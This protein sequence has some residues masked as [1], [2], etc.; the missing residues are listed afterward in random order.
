M[1]GSDAPGSGKPSGL[2]GLLPVGVAAGLIWLGWQ[3]V[4][5]PLSIFAPPE[6]AVRLAPGSADVLAH[7][8]EVEAMAGDMEDAAYLARLALS[9]APFDVEALRVL[10]LAESDAGRDDQADQ[11]MTL[12]GNWSLRD[13]VAHGWLVESR[14]R[15]GN[16]ASAFAHADTLIRRRADLRPQVFDLFSTA[17]EMDP[18]AGAYL[19]GELAESPPWRA[20]Y[21]RSLY[22]RPNGI[23]LLAS[24]AVGLEKTSA[25]FSDSELEALYTAL[26][27][28]RQIP[29]LKTV[30]QALGRP[31]AD[32]LLVNGAFADEPAVRPFGWDL[33][34]GPGIAVAMLNDDRKPELTALRV[35]HD[36]R[37][38]QPLATQILTL[39]PGTYRLTGQ[40]RLENGS[41]RTQFSWE[42][43][44]VGATEILG[45]KRFDLDM[46]AQ[47]EWSSFDVRFTVPGSGCEAQTLRLVPRNTGRRTDIVIWFSQLSL[48]SAR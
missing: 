7:A 4:L 19:L 38:P 9:K 27:E 11:L 22:K 6:H 17:A 23:Q 35:I 2:T 1:A 24:L 13:N 28:G 48:V 32:A 42:V 31:S 26:Y 8:A 45:E 46:A 44:C 30:R 47:A 5:V 16:Y 3:I 12:A 33:G 37:N 21:L 34:V 41:G 25:P 36:G 43:Q 14:L 18:A 10:A 40:Q 29:G 15:Q 39:A 20:E